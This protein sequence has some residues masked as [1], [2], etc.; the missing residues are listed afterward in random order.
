[1]LHKIPCLLIEYKK[2]VKKRIKNKNEENKN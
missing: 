1:M 2:H